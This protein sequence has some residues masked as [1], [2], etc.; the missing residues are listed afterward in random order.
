MA[1]GIAANVTVFGWIDAVLLHPIPG[2]SDSGR[3]A[4]L[5]AVAPNGDHGN[6]SY[7]DFR[8]YRDG[9]QASGVAASLANAFTVGD[10]KN[11]Q[12]LWGEFVSGNYFAVLGVR[13]EMGRA[14]SPEERGDAPGAY[15]VAVISHRV[16][17]KMFR[18]D[19]AVVGKTI[20]VNRRKLTI[21]GVAP[22]EFRGSVPGLTFGLWIPVVMAPEINGQGNW[23]LEQRTERQMWVTVR[24]KPGIEIGQI[25]QEAIACQRRIFRTDPS[26]GAGFSADV[27]PLWK[28]SIGAQQPLRQPLIVLMAVCLTLFLIVGAN[29]ANLQLARATTRLK[30]ISIRMAVG[31]SPW[32]LTR[33]LL[34]ESL[35]LAA[36]GG[37]G[38]VLLSLWAGQSLVWLFPLT[39]LP[40]EL[41]FGLNRYVLGF[42]ILLCAAAAVG[43][44]LA[45]AFHTVRASLVDNL[46]EGSRGTTGGAG[47]HRTRGLLVVSE[48][49][50][51]L[52]ALVGTGLLARSFHNAQAIHPGLDAR[53]VVF[54]QIYVE[55]FCHTPEQ[56]EQFC[57]RLRDRLKSLPGVGAVSYSSAI[58]LDLGNG[59]PWTAIEAQGYGQG[60][61][62]D[63]RVRYSQVAPAYFDALRIP[64]LT[65]G[66][67]RT[68]T[69]P[70]LRGS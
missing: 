45:P 4:T 1:L 64:C 25:R 7:R 2:A 37:L 68:A 61:D 58:P 43:T 14:F 69:T 17:Q 42:T 53:N 39:S 21:V 48:V 63:M 19:P 51:A 18:A 56:R 34:T 41:E 32:R 15:P 50:L 62:E 13:P 47:L 52:V 57:L 66:I 55:T 10:D 38:G 40:L 28:G 20:S 44:G 24:L 30:E 70:R 33:Q 12:R 27:A 67:S 65:A 59:N 36:L 26:E 35:A 31:A 5:E 16:W 22:P 6:T 9:S 54:S 60:K 49:A 3:L 46:K 29:V 11:P 8:D 23:L